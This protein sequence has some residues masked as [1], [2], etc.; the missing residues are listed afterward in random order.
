MVISTYC[1][2]SRG[3]IVDIDVDG[4]DTLSFVDPSRVHAFATGNFPAEYSEVTELA[5]KC[6]KDVLSFFTFA[7]STQIEGTGASLDELFTHFHEPKENRLGFSPT[8]QGT[9]LG[10]IL[11]DTFKTAVCERIR[12]FYERYHG[13]YSSPHIFLETTNIARDRTSDIVVRVSFK[14]FAEYTLMK[15]RQWGLTNFRSVSSDYWDSETNSWKTGEFNLPFV[16]RAKTGNEPCLLFTPQKLAAHTDHISSVYSYLLAAYARYEKQ[17][18]ILS[19]AVNPTPC[20]K[21]REQLHQQCPNRE[22]LLN[23]IRGSMSPEEQAEMLSFSQ[24]RYVS[25]LVDRYSI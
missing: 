12:S 14:A 9:C 13:L 5:K 21:R 1:P 11:E 10:D 23:F 3:V 16:P 22:S 18:D 19:G 25:W 4:A 15:A 2:Q 8:S 7:A 24:D 6:E 20:K 17:K